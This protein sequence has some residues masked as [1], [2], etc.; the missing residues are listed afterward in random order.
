MPY[1]NKDPKSDPNIDNH[2]Y[3]FENHGSFQCDGTHLRHGY[4][5]CIVWIAPTG[6]RP[7]DKYPASCHCKDLR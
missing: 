5:R 2:P 3:P 4:G 1:Y 7:V 6:I